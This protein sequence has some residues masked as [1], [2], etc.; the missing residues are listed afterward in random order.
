MKSIINF[1]LGG[2]GYYKGN[3]CWNTTDL[4]YFLA[5]NTGKYAYPLASKY[6]KCIMLNAQFWDY[7][8]TTRKFTDNDSREYAYII[9][10]VDGELV[11][12]PLTRGEAE[13]VNIHSSIK[14]EYVPVDNKYAHKNVTIDG[15]VVLSHSINYE[16]IVKNPKIT[17]LF[18]VHTHPL[19]QEQSGKDNNFF[20]TTDLNSF[21]NSNALVTGLV[22]ENIYLLAKTQYTP[23]SMPDIT[24]ERL[25]P[26][27]LFNEMNILVYKA[28]INEQIF[29]LI[30]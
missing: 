17:M 30:S 25:T 29:S 9:F 23:T 5:E 21:I 13:S 3:K 15:K 10:D 8:K 20:S 22:A 6:P 24:I 7:V 11:F 16:N 14:L 1:F 18:I 19:L 4:V 27:Y 12:S 28:K 26:E 2:L